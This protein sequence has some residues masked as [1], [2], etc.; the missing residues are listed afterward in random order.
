[1]SDDEMCLRGDHTDD[2]YT[3]LDVDKGYVP[4]HLHR[5]VVSLLPVRYRVPIK[6]R[7]MLKRGL[8]VGNRETGEC[9]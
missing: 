3:T 4:C 1:M 6:L 5:Q 2:L 7:E 8:E 9:L